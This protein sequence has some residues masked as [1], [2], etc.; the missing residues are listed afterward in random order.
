[1][2]YLRFSR[3]EYDA[4]VGVA[5]RLD[6]VPR[7]HAL[8]HLLAAALADSD[9]ALARRLACLRPGELRILHEHLYGLPWLAWGEPLTAEEVAALADAFGPL[10]SSSRFARPLK[11]A[12][13]YR[14]LEESPALAEKLH[15]LRPE[16]FEA[17][18]Q[19]VRQR[20]QRQA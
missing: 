14:L 1:M 11:R 4:L 15:Y 9:P 19:Q 16:Q 8:K 13:V 10:V 5:L 6:T 20:V 12:L 7:P 17:L 2:G 18:C 3:P